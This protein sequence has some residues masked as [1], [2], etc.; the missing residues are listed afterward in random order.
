MGK[1]VLYI[2]QSADG[3]IA[4]KNGDVDWLSLGGQVDYGFHDFFDKVKV[5]FIGNTT[6]QQVLS[7]GGEFPYKNKEVFV[8]TTDKTKTEDEHSKFISSNNVTLVEEVKT[9]TDGICWL[10]GGGKISAHFLKNKLVDEIWLYT[11]PLLL[12]SGIRLFKEIP[13]ESKLKLLKSR[14]FENG[15]MEMIY[16]IM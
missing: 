6:Y 3:Y 12:G 4:R 5:V 11:M 8:F 7:F 9:K 1:V 15:T 14:Q 16:E 13:V 10:I 2:A